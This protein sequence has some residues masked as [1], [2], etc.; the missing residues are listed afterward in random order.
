MSGGSYN[1]LYLAADLADLG[2]QRGDLRAMSDRLAELGYAEGAAAETRK[3]LALLE[4]AP[5]RPDL[6]AVWKAVE[7]WDS[8]DGGEDAVR[9]ALAGYQG[10][11]K[12]AA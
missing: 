12:E 4:E 10:D 5:V 3:L 11:K 8:F 1:Y 9:E 2:Q 6:A 7:R